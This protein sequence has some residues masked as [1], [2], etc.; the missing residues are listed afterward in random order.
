VGIGDLPEMIDFIKDGT[1]LA[2]SVQPVPQIGYW[3]IRYMVEYL[4]G[5]VLPSLFDTGSVV[6]NASN[7]DTYK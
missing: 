7:A 6:V 2:T 5:N 1:A 4:N 3:S